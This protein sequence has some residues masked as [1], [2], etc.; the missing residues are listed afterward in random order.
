[1]PVLQAAHIKPFAQD[2][3]YE[4][5]NGLLLRSDMHTLFDAG[6]LTVTPDLTIHV[7]HRL[8]D[9]FDNGKV[10][11]AYQGAQL[12]VVPDALQDRPSREYLEWHNDMV[13]LG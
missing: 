1:M 8:H 3:P 13:F 10:Y 5:P 12:A 9:D 4:V 7:S 11:Y 2:G 6:Y